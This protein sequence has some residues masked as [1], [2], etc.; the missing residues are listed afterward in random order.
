ME[1]T[2][3]N[4]FQKSLVLIIAMLLVSAIVIVALVRDRIVNNQQWTVSVVGQSKVAWQPDIAN[5]V[6]GVRVDKASQ[7]KDAVNQLNEQMNKIIEAIKSA[8]VPAEDIATQN[9]SLSPQYDVVNEI[10]KV[11]GY[12]ANQQIKIKVR[13]IQE[14]MK[15]VSQ[16]ID[17]ATEAG[18]NE[19]LGIGFEPNDLEKL[20]QEARVK[21]I[22]DA[23]S[24]AVE[25][26][27]AAGIRLGK[28]VGW[29]ENFIQAPSSYDYA[30]GKGGDFGGQG[31]FA[32][33]IPSGSYEVIAEL[34]VTYKI[35]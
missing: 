3:T 11:S 16:V 30:Y 24:K 8:G 17:K 13:G 27:Q 6:L 28:I 15:K 35:K 25:M 21:A 20:K 31:G 10:S 29:W 33:N 7:A 14:E 23:K 22:A 12:N 32:P 19:V 1:N 5:I 26:S 34:N 2:N 4:R 9:Y 18:A